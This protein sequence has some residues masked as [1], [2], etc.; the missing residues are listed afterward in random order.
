MCALT[1]VPFEK[2]WQ[3]VKIY[4]YATQR[5]GNNT[6]YTATE[7][8]MLSLTIVNKSTQRNVT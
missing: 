8:D 1:A 3:P 4:S 6:D 7:S 5:I 2:P